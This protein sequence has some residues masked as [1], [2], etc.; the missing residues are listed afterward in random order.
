MQ[1]AWYRVTVVRMERLGRRDA[2]RLVL[3]GIPLVVWGCDTSEPSSEPTGTVPEHA[4][5]VAAW[6][7]T[8]PARDTLVGE[9]RQRL[10]G[11][12]T[13]DSV[14]AGLLLHGARTVDSAVG[15]GGFHAVL[16]VEALR[17]FV[18]AGEDVLT[19]LVHGVLATL[20]AGGT[21]FALPE[22]SL[23][24]LPSVEGAADSLVNAV[25]TNDV[26][27]A[28]QACVAL[29][30]AGETATLHDA[31]LEL[32]PRRP[33]KLGHEAICTAKVLTTLR[34]LPGEWSE[35]VYRGVV[36]ALM[37]RDRPNGPENTELWH[38]SRERTMVLPADWTNGSDSDDEVSSVAEQLREVVTADAAVETIEGFLAGGLSPKSLW[39]G[40]ILAAIES[41]YAGS[42]YHTLTVTQ[43]N[44][45]AYRLAST[46]RIRLLMLLQAGVFI[47]L[48]HAAVG[49]ALPWAE[50]PAVPASLDEVFADDR[51]PSFLRAVGHLAEGGH[52]DA[53]IRR[54]RQT[55]LIGGFDHHHFKIP[56]AALREAEDFPDQFRPY[57]LAAT[58]FFAPSDGDPPSDAWQLVGG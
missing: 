46:D 39:D 38:A 1:R 45:D 27:V 20:A 43:A 10:D 22:V 18:R 47:A 49:L 53:F 15:G 12:W 26:E 16:Q 34:D 6:L 7:A 33:H 48:D 13:P 3:G 8:F 29:H 35:D 36:W 52:A 4:E 30:R 11:L 25:D 55:A 19:V 41:V 32:G 28:T 9:L 51:S 23:H 2:V 37:T 58:R 57:L 14:F 50:I 42:N 44:R 24:S 40:L 21:G 31:L 54:V 17:D 56:D 5:D